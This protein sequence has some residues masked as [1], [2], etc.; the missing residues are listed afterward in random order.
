MR[1]VPISDLVYTAQFPLKPPAPRLRGIWNGARWLM[2]HSPTDLADDWQNRNEKTGKA[3]FDLAANLFIYAA[4]KTNLRNRLISPYIPA[5][6]QRPGTIVS[7]ARLKYAG[8]WDPEPYAWTRF[9]RWLQWDSD[10]S[11]QLSTFAAGELKP[12]SAQLAVL[13]GTSAFVPSDQE[14]AA[15]RGY[16]EAGGTLL[17]DTCGGGGEFASFVE[18]VL[19]RRI[20]PLGK[21]AAI[22]KTDPLIA[23]KDSMDDLTQPLYRP[24]TLQRVGVEGVRL[25]TMNLGKGR[26]LYSPIDVTVGLLGTDTLGIVGYDPSSACSVAKNA[27]L[28]AQ[29]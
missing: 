22:D 4:G 13:T 23:G 28:A 16:V 9:D 12:G 1:N 24:E 7:V 25:R 18:S 21:L 19:L 6:A 2:I 27:V 3:S 20:A 8:N 29:R 10:L 15:L 26:I 17:I 14:I 5:P 11:L